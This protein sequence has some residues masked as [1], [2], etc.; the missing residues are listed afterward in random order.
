MRFGSLFSGI[1]G[2]DLGLERAGMECAWQVEIDAYRRAVLARHWPNVRRYE[3]VRRCYGLEWVDLIC[4]G[5]PCQEISRVG[6]RRGILSKESA[7]WAEMLRVIR[8]VRPRYALVENSTSLAV[9]GLERVLRDLAESGYDTEWDCLPSAAFGA[10]H[11]RD[12]LYLLAY[13]CGFRHGASPP[14]IF[15]GWS[16]SQLHGGWAAEPD[17]ARVADGIPG[18]V[19]RVAALGDA[20]TVNVAEW[21]GKRI[22]AV[23]RCTS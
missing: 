22:V 20:V 21:I 23:E 1:G 3:D 19:D 13:P 6:R 7:L 4:G 8:Q 11:I 16:S 18:R 14:T 12:R 15:A 2:I 10:P 5:F 9:N 17:V